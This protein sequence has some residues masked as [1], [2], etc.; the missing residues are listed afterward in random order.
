MTDRLDRRRVML[1]LLLA[2]PVLLV[3]STG[4]SLDAT[5]DS[6][7]T[8]RFLRPFETQG[9][10]NVRYASLECVRYGIFRPLYGLSFL[11][12]HALWGAKPLGYH[13]TDLLLTWGCAVLAFLLFRRRF[14]EMS[15]ALAV[16]IWAALP[17]QGD[18]VMTFLGRNDRLMLPFVLGALLLY[19]S[20]LER[21]GR[22][23]LSHQGAALLLLML[24]LL[25]KESV[26][27]YGLFLFLWGAVAAGKGFLRTLRGGLLLWLGI[28]LAAA[29]YIG[30]RAL[31]GVEMGDADPLRFG[32]VGYVE[33]LGQMVDWSL[34]VWMGEAAWGYLGGLLLLTVPLML[35]LGG[36][37]AAV[38]YGLLCLVLGV[39]HL[40]LFWLQH[41]FLWLPWLWGSLALAGLLLAGRDLLASALRRRGAL[42]A[43]LLTAMLFPA[44]AL[45][46]QERATR[47][48]HSI[49]LVE[50]AAAHLESLPPPAGGVYLIEEM[51]DENRGM[52]M[53]LARDPSDLSGE[54]KLLYH[55]E[56]LLRVRTGVDSLRLRWRNPEGHGTPE[57]QQA[58]I[59][60]I[61]KSST[62][63]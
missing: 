19:D 2:V 55:V 15:A 10:A 52:R 38:R 12:D 24:G 62:L 39:V 21:A 1:V 46:S 11:L 29:A 5:F 6:E 53:L 25:A 28:P 57:S 23:R 4:S 9:M 22:E 40:P 27:Y 3:G 49:R 32:P 59:D 56:N 63:P 36:I 37:P 20:S 35:L 51:L 58:R 43:G 42:L 61:L 18:S 8:I 14:G 7:T 34:P 16:L 41:C 33:Q 45:W 60:S 47:S 13:V 30:L 54:A 17:V 31:L 48:M 50:K 26:V 44:L